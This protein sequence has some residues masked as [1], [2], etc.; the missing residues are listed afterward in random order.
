MAHKEKFHYILTY[1]RL[2]YGKQQEGGGILGSKRKYYLPIL[3]III[4]G[5]E[6]CL[7]MRSE[8]TVVT[9][10]PTT[11]VSVKDAREVGIYKKRF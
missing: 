7:P 2:C 1:N 6:K 5:F 3:H 9:D 8:A 4:Q 10:D 11:G